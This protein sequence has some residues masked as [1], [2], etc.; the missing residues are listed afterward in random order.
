MTHCAPDAY[1]CHAYKLAIHIGEP[2]AY[3][4]AFLVLFVMIW[5]DA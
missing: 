2:T 5:G 4:V 1:T 3:V